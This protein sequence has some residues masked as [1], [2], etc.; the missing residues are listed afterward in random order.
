MQ[1]L[2]LFGKIFAP[3]NS[4]GTRTAC[5]AILEEKIEGVLGDRAS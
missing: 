1:R 3:S 4:S 5:I 2:E